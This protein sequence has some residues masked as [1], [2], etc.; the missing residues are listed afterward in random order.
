MKSIMKPRKKQLIPL[1]AAAILA[2][3]NVVPAMAA[4]S[5]ANIGING[6]G[7]QFKAFQLMTLETKLKQ[8]CGHTNEADHNKDC[9]DYLYNVNAKYADVLRQ[10]ATDAGVSFDTNNDGTISDNELKVGL[11]NMTATETRKYADALQPLTKDMEAEHT[12]NDT[13]TFEGVDQGWYLITETQKADGTDSYSLAIL[14]TGGREDITID[15]KEGIPSITKKI[16]ITNAEGTTTKVDASDASKG[17]IVNYETTITLP[18]NVTEYKDYAFTV[19]DKGNGIDL[20]GDI[21]IFVDDQ[22]ATYEGD[23][24]TA[25]DG[26]MFHKTIH[27]SGLKVNGAKA[28]ITKN[29]IITLKYKGQIKEEG[30]VNTNTGNTNE[31]WLE[32]TNNPYDENEKENTPKDKVATFTYTIKTNKVDADKAP[33]EG[34]GFTLYRKNGDTYEQVGMGET[35]TTFTFQGLG[36]GEY[37]L[38]ETKVPAG[39]SKAEDLI[40]SIRGIYETEANNPQLTGLEILN[41]DGEVI[42][43]GDDASFSID[44]SNASATTEVVNIRG[45]RLPGTGATSLMILTIGGAIF[46]LGGCGALFVLKRKKAC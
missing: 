35:G 17:D 40:F 7:K 45:V 21:Q 42:S 24:D 39:Y 10:A 30:F 6:N 22:E 11:S 25:T 46:I 18:D 16:V 33:L 19:H 13:K 15:A 14:D 4:T 38:S 12:I 8:N 5:G 41:K 27:L 1:T 44:L 28:E 2:A 36:P 26:C 3:M 29:S 9:Y 23:A 20:N 34:A 31:T 32:F 43:S 37:K